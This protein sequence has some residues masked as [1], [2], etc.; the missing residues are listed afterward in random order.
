[1]EAKKYLWEK[2][3][4]YWLDTHTLDFSLGTD[5]K[6]DELNVLSIAMSE[7]DSE[8]EQ[9]ERSIADLQVPAGMGEYD[10]AAFADKYSRQ[11]AEIRLRM[12]ALQTIKQ[13][14]K[15]R[16][17][18]YAIGIERQLQAQ[19]KSHSFLAEVHNEVNNY[20]KSRSDEVYTKLQKAVQLVDS[21]DPEDCSLLLTQVRRAMKACADFFYPPANRKVMCADGKERVLGDEQYLNRLYEFMGTKFAKSSSSDLLFS[22][23]DHLSVF[24]RRLNDVASKG[25]HAA[26]SPKEAKQG[27]LGLYMFLYNVTSRLERESSQETA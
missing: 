16:C 4:E 25:V 9:W 26:V 27:L 6:G 13:R 10:T 2:S 21:T 18:N 5:D 20:F 12:K 8:L 23:L 24:A 7:I 19:S 3:A 1:M 17:V 11:K 14:I 15:T 22:E